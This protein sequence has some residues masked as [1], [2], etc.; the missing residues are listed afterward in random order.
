MRKSFLI[1]TLLIFWTNNAF[2]QT[3]RLEEGES[4]PYTGFLITKEVAEE[5]A[6]N[7]L[8]VIQLKDLQITQESLTE[9]H[10]VSAKEARK[11]LTEAQIETFTYTLGAFVLGVL[12]TG[13]AAKMNQKIG[14]M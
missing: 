13:F 12:V 4:A 3:L 9:Y 6:K 8:R 2:T 1:L 14:D 5:A 7:K 11:K 10:R